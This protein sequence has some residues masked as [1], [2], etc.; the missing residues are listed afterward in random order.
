MF[1]ITDHIGH[2]GKNFVLSKHIS[3]EKKRQWRYTQISWANDEFAV[4]D[5]LV[6]T[7]QELVNA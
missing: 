3:Q 5:E 6:K 2:D 7:T 1:K 4:T